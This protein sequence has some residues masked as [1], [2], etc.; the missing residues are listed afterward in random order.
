MSYDIWMEIDTGGEHPAS[1]CESSNMTSNVSPMWAKALGFPLADLDGVRGYKALPDL[2]R[3]IAHMEDHPTAYRELNPE[4]G[5]GDT[6]SALKF[7]REILAMCV[8]H[9]M[10]QIRISR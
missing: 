8:A 6:E 9:P 1:V 2:R 7:L 10:A 5:W 4:N 3:A